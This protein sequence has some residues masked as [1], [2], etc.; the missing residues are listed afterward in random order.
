[1]AVPAGRG[2][3]GHAGRWGGP[4][5]LPSR[6]SALPPTHLAAHKQAVLHL[7]SGVHAHPVVGEPQGTAW[8]AAKG[9]RPPAHPLL[10]GRPPST[11]TPPPGK[12]NPRR[13]CLKRLPPSWQRP[14]GT[15]ACA[16][17]CACPPLAARLAVSR[18][19]ISP[20]G[21][22]APARPGAGTR[23]RAALPGGAR[24][25]PQPG[26]F[27]QKGCFFGLV[28]W[29]FLVCCFFLLRK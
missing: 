19:A 18:E 6:T 13:V 26:G 21:R 29:V 28:G 5:G 14:P 20:R 1:M 23:R 12:K 3:A 22:A 17:A 4:S 11:F 16:C 9:A 8:A 2:L 10:G 27:K 24:L 7:S 25:A 15:G